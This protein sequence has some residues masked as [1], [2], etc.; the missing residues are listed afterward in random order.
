[1]AT[2]RNDQQARDR[3][4]EAQ[5][6]VDNCAQETRTI[7]DAHR[8]AENAVL[9]DPYMPDGGKQHKI[10][11]LRSE[12]NEKLHQIEQRT[13]AAQSAAKEA[14][15]FLTRD[16]RS[17]TEQTRDD[18]RMRLAWERAKMML[19]NRIPAHEVVSRAAEAGDR[20]TIEA[21]EFF[22][23]TYIEADIRG[24]GGSE[25]DRREQFA[26]LDRTLAEAKETTAPPAVKA[27]GDLESDA[28]SVNLVATRA[29]QE[30]QG[31]DP[32]SALHGDL[33]DGLRDFT[34]TIHIAR[35]N[36]ALLGGMA[37]PVR[38]ERVIRSER[39]LV[40]GRHG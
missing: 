1:M 10:G 21:M 39:D 8:K 16:T 33:P 28:E 9:K 26:A 35:E 4:E 5:K 22:G 32:I 17:A 18:G 34:D 31:G 40:G 12:T 11:L 30:V 25:S 7:L 15:G 20:L 23:R 13:Q 3:M 19:D 6:N 37:P 24:R 38:R 2:F 27:L 36:A 29:R 14:A